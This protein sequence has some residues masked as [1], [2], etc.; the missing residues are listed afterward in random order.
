MCDIEQQDK[1]SGGIGSLKEVHLKKAIS[2]P[3]K[4]WNT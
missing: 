4:T 3:G 1:K 2:L